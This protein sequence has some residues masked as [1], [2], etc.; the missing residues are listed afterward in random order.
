MADENLHKV[1]PVRSRLLTMPHGFLTARQS[2]HKRFDLISR[3]AE[4]VFVRQV[5]SARVLNVDKPFKRENIPEA[6]AMVTTHRALMLGIVTADCAPILFEDV[7]AGVI[8]A[9][10]AGWRGAQAGIAHATVSEMEKL[11]ASRRA[12]RASIGPCIRQDSY[13]VDD[14]FREYFVFPQDDEFFST[15]RDGHWQFDLAG[16]VAAQLVSLLGGDSVEITGIDTYANAEHFHSFRRATHLGKASQGR[17]Y[18][19]IAIS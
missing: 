5:H 17:Q 7:E 18:S 13:E 8:G 15:G 12:I 9:A 14:A 6:D 3:G 1:E 4:P 16:Y 10:H 11:G 19:L 2:E